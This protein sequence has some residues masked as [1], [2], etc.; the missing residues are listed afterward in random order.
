MRLTNEWSLG[1]KVA[2]RLLSSIRNQDRRNASC[3]AELK[4]ELHLSLIVRRQFIS[5]AFFTPFAYLSVDLF[6]Y[7]SPL[8]PTPK[9]VTSNVPSSCVRN[10]PV[11]RSNCWNVPNST[12]P[13][14]FPSHL[15]RLL[16][17]P[18]PQGSM[19]A[20]EVALLLARSPP[21]NLH[22]LLSLLNPS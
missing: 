6:S 1:E 13:I 22:S 9:F 21:D 17:Y 10:V 3:E 15:L 19:T 16:P 2:N 14:P 12:M 8:F 5:H 20:S 4:A 7:P 11:K 18:P